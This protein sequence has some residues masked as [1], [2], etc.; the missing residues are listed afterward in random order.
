MALA[1]TA[2]RTQIAAAFTAMSSITRTYEQPSNTLQD[3]PAAVIYPPARVIDRRAQLRSKVYIVRIR[4]LASDRDLDK[5]AELIDTLAEECIDEFD[6]RVALGG[7]VA[8]V[9]SQT[10]EE[11]QQFDYAGKTLVGFDCLLTLRFHDAVGFTN[12]SD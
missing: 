9:E 7:K 5:A 3:L 8:V 4:V 2:A 10:I 6:T 11:A 1:W 12:V